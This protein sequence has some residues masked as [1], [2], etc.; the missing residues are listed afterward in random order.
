MVT[1][2]IRPLLLVLA[3][4]GLA[5]SQAS[6]KDISDYRLG[7]QVTE[8]IVTPVPL[9]VMDPLATKA[10]KDKEEARVP[11]IFRYHQSALA[12]VEADLRETFSLAR[13]NFLFLVQSSFSRTRLADSQIESEQ[14]RQVIES[15]KQRNQNFP[16]NK[17]MAQEWAHGSVALPEQIMILARIDQ[18]MAGFI[19]NEIPTNAPELGSQVLLVPVKHE[20]E[21]IT[22]EEVT[23]RGELISQTNLLTLGRA[24]RIMLQ[25]FASGEEAMA[26]FAAQS[27]RENCFVATELTQ[28]ARTR[29][30]DPL[31]VADNY[32]AGQVIARQGAFVDAKIMAALSQLQEKTAAGR[33]AAQVSFEKEKAGLAQ[34]LASQV[35]ESNKWL[36]LGMIGAGGSLTLI[37]LTLLLR[38]RRE[39]EVLPLVLSGTT[40]VPMS[41]EGRVSPGSDFWQQ[42]AWAAE[43]K[44]Q[45]AHEALRS[46]VLAK[47]KGK[48]VGSLASQR[49][50][51]LETQS[52]AAAEMAEMER[53]LNDLHAPLQERLRAYEARIADLEKALA[54]KGKE[55]RELIKAKI[56]L[57]RKQLE[58][59]RSGSGNYLQFN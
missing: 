7:D 15:F 10:L 14:F 37:V 36:V 33:L 32:Q 39:L 58:A 18:A 17:E 59:E 19:R 12:T 26:K 50:E 49:A 38:R 22:L 6:A 41:S 52:S 46:G 56:E 20:N 48:L 5:V 55:N 45:R 3:S 4:A 13:S 23:A 57:M 24:R 35:R 1:W 47:L 8:D 44:A 25:K 31:F 11:V 16:L 42:R 27:L 53:R 34:A 30:T 51:M 2:P 21:T 9:M 29:H 54:A 43:Q 28:A 40:T